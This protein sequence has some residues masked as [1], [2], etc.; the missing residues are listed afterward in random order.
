MYD[1]DY[2]GID[3]EA[4]TL[5]KSME[6]PEGDDDQCDDGNKKIRKRKKFADEDTDDEFI[7]SC[8]EK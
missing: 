1:S 7:W 8:R 2:S 3:M 4:L 5:S 6:Q